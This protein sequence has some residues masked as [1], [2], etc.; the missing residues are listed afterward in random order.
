VIRN[1]FYWAEDTHSDWVEWSNRLL[2][3]AETAEA[4]V[5]RE[6]NGR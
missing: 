4:A 1:G 3:L 2:E 6:L 5:T